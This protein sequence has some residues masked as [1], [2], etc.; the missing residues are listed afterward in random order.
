[1]DPSK[2]T[3]EDLWPQSEINDIYEKWSIDQQEALEVENAHD[4]EHE[5]DARRHAQGRQVI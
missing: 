4:D 1:M 2:Q 5:K 3:P